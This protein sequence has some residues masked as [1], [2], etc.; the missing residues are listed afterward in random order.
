MS[1]IRALFAELTRRKV[2][3]SV[4]GYIVLVWLLAQG[5]ADLFPYFGLPDWTLRAF[6]Y[7]G[8]AFIPLVVFISWRYN[9]TTQG[10]VRDAG[11]RHDRRRR[12]DDATLDSRDTT[13]FSVRGVLNVDWE[14]TD[15]EAMSLQC[16]GPTLIGRERE[17]DV[18]LVDPRVSRR[19]AE[20]TA[21]DGRWAVRDLG[22]ANGTWLDGQRIDETIL[23]PQGVLRFDRQG[24]ALRFRVET[25][26]ST[27]I[28]SSEDADGSQS[29]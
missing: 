8:I 6:V 13:E 12:S 26:D 7:G 1:K 19:H 29:P 17:C 9:L 10:F 25:D 24:P 18:R 16:H 28:T 11:G 2:V 5:F 15:G 22:S 14:K 4:G 23:P 27:L 21:R 20:I 3:Q